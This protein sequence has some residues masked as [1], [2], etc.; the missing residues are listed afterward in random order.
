MIGGSGFLGSSIVKSLKNAGFEKVVCGDLTS[1]KFLD[2]EYVKLD[3]L[4]LNNITKKIN[5]ID[6]I[7]NC[8]GQITQPFN[9]CYK[10][11][12]IGTMNISK[13]VAISK[14]RLIH[15]S[16]VAVYGS[17]DY[18]NEQSPLNPETNY[19]TAKAFAEEILLENYIQ[20]RLTIL[21]L[22]NLY[23]NR[24]NKGIIAYLLRSY[25]SDRKLNFNNDGSLS[26]SFMHV[27]DCAD[28]IA[29]VV[30]NSKLAGI[31]NIKGH[32][33]YSVKDL[34]EQFEDHFG[35]KFEKSFNQDLP[36]ENIDSLD[37]SKL[38]SI[39]D[40]QPQWHLFDF[41]GKEFGIKAY[42]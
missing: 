8:T 28:I 6:L 19:A 32:E 1:N 22:S 40:L 17:A 2:C 41:M 3:V 4:D 23:G 5:N 18:C 42:V 7:I 31:Y 9:L 36:W 39:I 11:N 15:I 20:K 13:A 35:I 33:T 25:H 16:T 14:A 30:K 27:E 34:V 10:L 26:R 38:R 37:D 21:R 12:S 29:E 24:Q